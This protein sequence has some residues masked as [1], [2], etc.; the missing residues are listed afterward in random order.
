M[1]NDKTFF[2]N[3]VM[4]GTQNLLLGI[5]KMSP[6]RDAMV[7]HLLHF[8][9]GHGLKL[10]YEYPCPLKYCIFIFKKNIAKMP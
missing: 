10:C 4:I 6:A 3:T 1:I 7:K 5:A 2:Q 8:Q 9:I